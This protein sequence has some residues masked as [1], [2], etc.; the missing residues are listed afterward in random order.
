MYGAQ[1]FRLARLLH[2]LVRALFPAY[3]HVLSLLV[4]LDHSDDLFIQALRVLK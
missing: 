2:Q 3:A 4:V 1:G